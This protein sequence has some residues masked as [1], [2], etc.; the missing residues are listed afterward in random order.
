[1]AILTKYSLAEAVW[2]LLEGGTPGAAASVGLDEIKV[3]CGQVINSLL[4]TEY[5]Q[6]N[7]KLGETIPNGSVLG[8]YEGISP[9]SWVTGKS[10]ATL[11]IKP[12]KLPRNIGVFSVFFTADPS[13]EFIPLQ[14]GQMNLINSQPLL[15]NLLGQIGYEV[16]GN[17]LCFT[18]DLPQLYPDQTLSM[19]LVIM[20]ISQYS[21][22]DILPL[23]P[24]FEWAVIKEVYGMYSTQ[25]VPDKIVN[26]TV[27]EQK[28]I[29]T[30]EQQQR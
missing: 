5:F 28:T 30:N 14:M 17:E 11:P 1:M 12:L 26:P 16:Y 24:E 27:K 2:N 20:D 19:R 25:P 29:N 23:P 18:K 6:V 15:N 7:G 4:K 3:G 10:K 21:D 13:R 22:Y 8:L 9:Y